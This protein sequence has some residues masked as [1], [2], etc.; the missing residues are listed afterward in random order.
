MGPDQPEC[1]AGRAS[2]AKWSNTNTVAQNQAK[3][4]VVVVESWQASG[5]L[6]ELPL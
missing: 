4:S 1:G 3:M 6:Q 5:K 2:L